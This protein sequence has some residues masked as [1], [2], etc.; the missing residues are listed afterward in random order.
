MYKPFWIIQDI[1]VFPVHYSLWNYYFPRQTLGVEVALYTLGLY[2]LTKNL[3]EFFCFCLFDSCYLPIGPPPLLPIASYW[4]CVC[5][6]L[7][8]LRIL[9]GFLLNFSCF[10]SQSPSLAPL[11]RSTSRSPSFLQPNYLWF[12]LEFPTAFWGSPQGFP[13]DT[14]GSPRCQMNSFFSLYT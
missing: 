12:G 14:W 9:Q 13:E 5:P 7:Y 6:H 2:F 4:G 8:L 10:P 11:M 3:L 1:C